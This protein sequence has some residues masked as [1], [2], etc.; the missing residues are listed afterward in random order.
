MFNNIMEEKKQKGGGKMRKAILSIFSFFSLIA[1]I[2]AEELRCGKSG[3]VMYCLDN[4][5]PQNL[6]VFKVQK[7]EGCFSSGREDSL[8]VF[9]DRDGKGVNIQ[10]IDQVKLDQMIK[11]EI[12]EVE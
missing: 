8:I 10:R 5:F 1:V 2:H 12:R 7:Q 9:C 6:F 11:V 3:N 4:S